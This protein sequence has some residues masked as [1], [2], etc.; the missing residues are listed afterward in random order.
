MTGAALA[1]AA[2][3]VVAT[4]AITPTLNQ[5]SITVANAGYNLA[6][7][8]DIFTIPSGEWI[9]SYF[10]GY[11]GIVGP[12]NPLPLEPWASGC[13]GS[14]Y[15]AG[16]SGVSYLALDAL[17]N[18][19]GEGWENNK[20]WGVGAVNYFYEGGTP[21]A[22]IEYIL[23]ESIG[24]A[25]PVLGVLIT[26][27]FAGPQLV[28]VVYDNAIQLLSEAALNLPVIGDYVYGALNAYLGPASLDPNFRFYTDGLTGILN[29]TI[30]V[31]TG[32]APPSPTPTAESAAALAAAPAAAVAAL[33]GRAAAPVVAA[34]TDSAVA[35]EVS[36]PSASDA[37]ETAV[38][39]SESAPTGSSE[40]AGGAAAT[41]TATDA[42]EAA[43]AGDSPAEAAAGTGTE[44]PASSPAVE[45]PRKAAAETGSDT[46]ATDPVK[47]RKRPVRDAVE[48]VGA[49]IGS[50]LKGSKAGETAG[51]EAT[52]DTA[53]ADSAS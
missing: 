37:V 4:P 27:I 34:V 23:Q 46:S 2:A 53:A 1:S 42:E 49:A 24:A 16:W 14:C 31:L 11:G 15:I 38:T 22:G 8:S 48:K 19:N 36:A 50:A 40:A 5:A 35:P 44:T 10:Q 29:Y 26:L 25:N 33:S 20:D 18:G 28:T 13:N 45:S 3:L 6:T 52:A 12:D 32:N 21:G 41:E 43:P 51:A 7:F 47:T 17:I 9:A 39:Q 30:D